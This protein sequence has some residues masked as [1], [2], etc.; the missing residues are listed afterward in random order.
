VPAAAL[1]CALAVGAC[2]QKGAQDG[3]QAAREAADPAPSG[4]PSLLKR[5]AGIDPASLGYDV[6]DAH[7]PVRVVEMSDFGCGYCR[8]FHLETWPVL[9]KEFVATGKVHWKFVPFV[10]GMFAHSGAAT[11]AAECAL[12]QGPEAFDAM[13]A[14]LWQDQ[15]V[16]KKAPDAAAVV[17]G[18]A[19]EA[20]LDLVRYDRCV[21]TGEPSER[22]SA[23]G[24]LAHQLGVRGTPTFFILGYPPLPGALPTNTFRQLLT[25]AY[26]K[27][28]GQGT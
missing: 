1:A 17:R 16:W 2:S 22:I 4:A 14:R 13:Q 27:A 12:A 21:S 7:A 19:R 28:T 8:K 18:W 11:T 25:E 9:E 6:G 15:A 26:Q 24:E 23:S 20:G 3:S 10:T 5:P